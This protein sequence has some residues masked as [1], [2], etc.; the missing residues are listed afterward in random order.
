MLKNPK[1]II[2]CPSEELVEEL[3]EL[4][5]EGGA[6]WSIDEIPS[7]HN[8]RWMSER[9]CYWIRNG[10]LSH[11][12]KGYAEDHADE[13]RDFIKCTFYGSDSE[14][15]DADFEAIISA[16]GVVEGGRNSVG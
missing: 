4:L 6:K 16:G 8:S 12:T 3:M 13:Y 11:G 5:A 1:I 14:I 10:K 2:S 15:S 9:T 7:V